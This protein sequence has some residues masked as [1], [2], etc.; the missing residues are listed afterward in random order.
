MQRDRLK[1]IAAKLR[2]GASNSEHAA[3]PSTSPPAVFLEGVHSDLEHDNMTA[4]E[5]DAAADRFSESAVASSPELKKKSSLSWGRK[6]TSRPSTS[7]QTSSIKGSETPNGASMG[8]TSSVT[9]ASSSFN[10]S[11][12]L[13]PT[14]L[15]KGSNASED[16]NAPPAPKRAQAA[17]IRRLLNG[18]NLPA[19]VKDDPLEALRQGIPDGESSDSS[20]PPRPRHPVLTIEGFGTDLMECLKNFTAVEV[21]EGDN[22]FACHRCWK[23][24]TGRIS[25]RASSSG[26]QQTVVEED[27]TDDGPP[28]PSNAS[29]ISNMPSLAHAAS[30]SSSDSPRGSGV[31]I[32]II[33]VVQSDAIDSALQLDTKDQRDARHRFSSATMRA[34]SPLRS[35]HAAND[36]QSQEAEASL[37]SADLSSDGES[38]SDEDD[39]PVGR[40][41]PG[42]PPRRKSTHFVLQRAFK[43]YLVAK[44][45]PVMV[46]HFKRFQQIGKPSS[47]FYATS[48]TS[49]RKM[50][51]Y[52]SF[53]EILDV[54]PFMAPDRDDYKP[55][56]MA[57]GT[58]HARYQ[59]H[60]P[61]DKGPK[62]TPM[63][64]KLY[65]E[66]RFAEPG[67]TAAD[68]YRIRRRRPHR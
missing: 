40:N 26:H 27:E 9:S 14:T 25:T 36:A 50:D 5:S 44:A 54:A 17:Y 65:G 53:P 56:L 19:S 34:P 46:F 29:I 32:P 68:I 6:R 11:P 12:Q 38:S 10:L 28:T 35:Q 63:L 57:D 24:K 62:L 47:S 37:I 61:G 49:L 60:P 67:V 20:H 64:Y 15:R 3:T 45:P 7:S 58:L 42:P 23:Y 33:S 1:A 39:V 8:R 59:D 4:D 48:F 2:P 52:V 51:D 21:L 31:D 41:R 13:R 16:P 22:A 55:T 30:V 66:L 18:P 43:R